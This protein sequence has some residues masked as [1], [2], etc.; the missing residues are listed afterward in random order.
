MVE[1]S[2]GQKLKDSSHGEIVHLDPVFS[3]TKDPSTAVVVEIAVIE[4]CPQPSVV[5]ALEIMKK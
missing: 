3:A 1:P 2:V 4:I 5:A